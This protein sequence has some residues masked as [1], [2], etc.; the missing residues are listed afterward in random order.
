M[1]KTVIKILGYTTLALIICALF[2]HHQTDILAVFAHVK[3][4]Y[5]GVLSVIHIPMIALGGLSFKFLCSHYQIYLRWTEWAGLSFIANF[6]NQ[7]LPY[8]LG[9]GFRYIY[10]RQHFQMSNAQFIYVMLVYFIFT[11]IFCAFFALIGWLFSDLPSSFNLLFYITC[12]IGLGFAGFIIWLKLSSIKT[13]QS[14]GESLKAL[15]DLLSD[16][17]IFLY[18]ALS[19]IGVN[20]LTAILFYICLMAIHAPLPITHC[21]F[22]VGILT[23]AMLFPLTP[24]NIGVLEALFGTLTQMIYHDFSMGFAAIALYRVSQWIPSIILGSSFSFLLAGSIL[25]SIKNTKIGASKIVN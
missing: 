13:S 9:M 5:V 16:P 2:Y 11:I 24:G 8:R 21:L 7:L 20:I 23:A 17:K 3:W 15:Q 12:A 19:L 4:S 14:I 1:R 18:S 10:M 6:L 25:P 22:L